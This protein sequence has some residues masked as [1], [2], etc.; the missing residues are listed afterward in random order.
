MDEGDERTRKPRS[1][2]EQQMPTW[3]LRGIDPLIRHRLDGNW[4]RWKRTVQGDP[5]AYCGNPGGEA[6]HIVPRRHGG[7]DRWHNIT[8][9]CHACNRAKGTMSALP[10]IAGM[11]A[12]V[13]WLPVQLGRFGPLRVAATDLAEV[14]GGRNDRSVVR[15]VIETLLDRHPETGAALAYCKRRHRGHRHRRWNHIAGHPARRRRRG[16]RVPGARR[17]RIA[18]P[19]RRAVGHAAVHAKRRHDHQRKQDGASG[20]ERRRRAPGSSTTAPGRQ[21]DGV[22]TEARPV[23]QV[24][25]EMR[26]TIPETWGEE[27]NWRFEKR[28][29]PPR[30]AT[31]WAWPTHS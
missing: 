5:C 9:S 6:D 26:G 10:F 25:P 24:L 8:G 14:V 15:T 7:R 2:H 16:Q 20:R 11:T 19:R 22:T 18:A 31:R 23:P 4:Q 30:C 3:A 1:A 28:S 21:S 12:E 27:K 29:E 17:R 13:R